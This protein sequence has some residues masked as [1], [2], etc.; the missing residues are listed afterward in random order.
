M[1]KLL[2]R[3]YE[4]IQEE[5]V[6]TARELEVSTSAVTDMTAFFGQVAVVGIASVGFLGA[7]KPF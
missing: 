2:A 6:G 4:S 3:R 5:R 7:V 1:E